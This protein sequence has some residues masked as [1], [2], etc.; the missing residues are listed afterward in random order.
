MQRWP[1][2]RW[3]SCTAAGRRRA[4]SGRIRRAESS[5][6]CTPHAPREEESSRG[7]ATT[8][9][10]KVLGSLNVCS[11]QWVIRQYDHEVQGGSVVKP[12]VGVANDGPSDAAVVRPVLAS[13][14]GLVIACGM[15]PHYG[16][17]DTYHMAASAIDEAVRNCVAVGADPERIAMLDNFCWGN[18]D[19][20]ETLGSLGPSGA[21]LPRSGH[22]A[23]HA[24]HQ[25]QG[26]LE[27]RISLCGR[28]RPAANDC[29]SAVAVDQRFG[30]N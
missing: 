10:R 7:T 6:E 14:R 23:G 15:N 16:D 17:F 5:A 13:R 22:R 12:L 19:R 21:G 26:Q 25:R 27:Q 3:N 8:T 2:C 24:I 18:T 20:P 4:R 30:P 9:L 11:K 29:H 28:R 1:I